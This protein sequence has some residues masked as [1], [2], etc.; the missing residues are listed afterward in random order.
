MLVK[1]NEV[2]LNSESYDDGPALYQHMLDLNL[3]EIVAK[4][5]D[6]VY[7]EGERAD[8]WLK[9]PTRKRQEFVIGGWTE[10]DK[11]KSFRSLL[12]GAYENGEFIWIGT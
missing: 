11:A 5:K 10:S 9:T 1:D 7:V 12:F 3:E 8:D 2:F 4:R 6:S